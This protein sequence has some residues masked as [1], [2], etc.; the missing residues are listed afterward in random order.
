MLQ[1]NQ[2]TVLNAHTHTLLLRLQDKKH[3]KYLEIPRIFYQSFLNNL[4]RSKVTNK[5]KAQKK[6]TYK[7]FQF[8]FHFPNQNVSY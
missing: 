3:F 1:I 8:S 6:I 7:T 2:A 4:T 5:R